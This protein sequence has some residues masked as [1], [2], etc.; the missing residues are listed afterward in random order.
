MIGCN[1]G[2]TESLHV[3]SLHVPFTLE[4]T[5]FSLYSG[6]RI[7][8]VSQQGTSCTSFVRMSRK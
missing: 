1:W 3:E 2:T 5:D 6:C 7:L 8:Q 4:P